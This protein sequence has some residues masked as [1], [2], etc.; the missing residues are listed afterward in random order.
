M[1]SACLRSG[2]GRSPFSGGPHGACPWLPARR[3]DGS[4]EEVWST[5]LAVGLTWHAE[6]QRQYSVVVLF[7]IGGI[8]AGISVRVI[9]GRM[10]GIWVLPRKTVAN[11]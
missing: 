11:S 8:Q 10:M 1:G 5:W 9:V 3:W 7:V 4:G 6:Q 2:E